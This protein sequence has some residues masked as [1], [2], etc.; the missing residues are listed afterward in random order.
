MKRAYAAYVVS[1]I[2]FGLNGVV[3]SYI[4]LPSDEIVFLRTCIGS[5]VLLAVFL[6]LR[7]KFTFLQYQR[8]FIYVAVSGI[9]MGASWIFLYEAYQLIG[10]SLSSLAY[11][12]GPVIV[13]LFAPVLFREKLTWAGIGSFTIVLFGTFFVNGD[14][15][16][17]GDNGWG[18]FCG[19]MSAVMHAAMV[20]CTKKVKQIGGLENSV[21]QLIFSF[22]S[23]V[24]FMGC[25]GSGFSFEIAAEDWVPILIL[26]VFNTGICCYLYFSSLGHLPIQT[27][28]ICGYLEPLSAVVFS[29]LLLGEV[30]L[31]IQLLGAALILGGALAG[32]MY[33]YKKEIRSE[34][35][36]TK[37][38]N[39][40]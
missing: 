40:G 15:L 25:M 21:W 29:V 37:K 33:A 34:L 12:C 10:V 19:G 23:V 8:D 32:E 6:L 11:Y 26:G 36:N 18:L 30:L 16:L 13:M 27:V 7:E 28:S 2:L 9:A 20:I 38:K 5:V 17:T 24:V 22:L 31:P 35:A 4:S 39:V 14:I 1:L 3:A